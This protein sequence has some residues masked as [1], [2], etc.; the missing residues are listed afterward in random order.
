MNA[1]Y[2]AGLSA[3]LVVIN[4][5]VVRRAPRSGVSGSSP[6]GDLVVCTMVL[7]DEVAISNSVRGFL[8]TLARKYPICCELDVGHPNSLSRCQPLN[9]LLSRLEQLNTLSIRTVRKEHGVPVPI[10][11]SVLFALPPNINVAP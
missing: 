3:G 7:L 9:C 6:S 5:E 2:F 4:D 11:V 10:L 1:V 8:F